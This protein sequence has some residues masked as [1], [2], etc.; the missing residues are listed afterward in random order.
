MPTLRNDLL[1]NIRLPS[2]NFYRILSIYTTRLVSYQLI[3]SVTL[4]HSDMR[5]PNTTLV[6]KLD[7]IESIPTEVIVS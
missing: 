3:I 2:I 4:Y 1:T 5:S 7:N 6:L